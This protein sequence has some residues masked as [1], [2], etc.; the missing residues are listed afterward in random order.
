MGSPLPANPTSAAAGC[1]A[2]ATFSGPRTHGPPT[3][4]SFY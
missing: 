3:L 4:L 1:G 2:A